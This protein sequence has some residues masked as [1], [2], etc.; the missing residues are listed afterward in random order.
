MDEHFAITDCALI[1]IATGEKAHNLRELRDGLLRTEDPSVTYYH[2]WGGLLRPYF[3]DPEYQNQFS[4]WA[5][6]DLRDRFLAERLA[7]INPAGY[8]TIDDLRHEVIDVLEDRMDEDPISQ[9]IEAEHPFFFIRSQIVVFDTA[10]RIT[11]PR[12]FAETIP[13]L[14]IGSLFYHF[15]DARRRTKSG[16]DDFS[17][18]FAAKG[19]RYA[20]LIAA[21][22]AVD[23]Y[24]NS[25]IE[26][27]D[28]L[29]GLFRAHLV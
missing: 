3:V 28:Q 10:T 6:H 2:F 15:I 20:D 12:A 21:I 8:D 25:L 4:G 11:N 9:R 14:S 13:Q 23:P 1:A 7:I 16:R 22:N 24:F 29:S 26:L 17:E 27:R 19:D 18:W 5:Y